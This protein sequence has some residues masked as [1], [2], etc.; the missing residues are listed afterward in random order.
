MLVA[1]N[2]V[3]RSSM[4]Y[5]IHTGGGRPHRL[6]IPNVSRHPFDGWIRLRRNEIHGPDRRSDVREPASDPR[7]QLTGRTCDKDSHRLGLR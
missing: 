1:V 7:P 2:A 6:L 4:D 3:E 5:T